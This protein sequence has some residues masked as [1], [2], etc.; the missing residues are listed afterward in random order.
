MPKIYAKVTFNV[1][2]DTDEDRMDDVM[3]ALRVESCGD[4]VAVYE[5]EIEEYEITDSK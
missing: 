5:S 2:I 1:I 4:D 3:C